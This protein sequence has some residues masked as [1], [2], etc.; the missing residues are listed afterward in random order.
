MSDPKKDSHGEDK[1]FT[2][3]EM[4][5]FV[6]RVAWEVIPTLAEALIREE[7]DKQLAD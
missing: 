1:P 5:A 4:K 6:E 7:L 3:G 2:E